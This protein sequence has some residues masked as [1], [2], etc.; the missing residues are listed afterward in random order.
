MI[1]KRLAAK[2]GV[3]PQMKARYV[4]YLAVLP[5]YRTECVR[6]LKE[7]LGANLEIFVSSA[8]LD[9]SVRTGIPAEYYEELS[10]TRFL[11]DRGFIQRG[12]FGRAIAADTTIVDLNPRSVSAW[13][14]LLTRQ[15]LG[16]RS[17][18]WGHIHPRAG[19]SSSTSVLRLA[20]RR[21]AAGT[22][23]YTYRDAAK[24]LHDLPGQLVWT[25]PN[26]LYS[27]DQ[28]T[29]AKS[30][31]DNETSRVDVLYV[32]RF[33][34]AKKVELLVRGFAEASAKQPEMRLTLIGGGEEE[35]LL[36]GLTA[37]LGIEGRVH[38]PGWIDD[39]AKLLPYY[40]RAFCSASPG[41]AGLGLTQSLGFGI[42][43]IVA[44]R[45]PHSPE[46]ELE[47]SGGVHYFPSD[48]VSGAAEAILARWDERARL[49]DYELSE[50]TKQH[51]SAEAMATGLH[52]ALVGSI[53]EDAP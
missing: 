34:P 33:A 26:A 38:F 48:S 36:R 53:G 45:E 9:S 14:I 5:K 18:V 10:M 24:A 40:G 2:T 11:G 3:R 16:R 37:E 23:S 20:M 13:M 1:G 22:V 49:P 25:A 44:D 17:L 46:I 47:A 41:F 39:V 28:F 51:Y 27:R 32:G 29:V 30:A 31:T 7:A 8:H 42:P 43:M 50:Y 21:L 6:K 15:V 35:Q 19:S 4:L 12:H 52:A